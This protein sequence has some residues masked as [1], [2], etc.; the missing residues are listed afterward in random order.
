MGHT[1]EYV[2][3]IL[4]RESFNPPTAIDV[5]GFMECSLE[6]LKDGSCLAILR[7]GSLSPFVI[8]DDDHP[9]PI[10]MQ[11]RSRDGCKTWEK[12]T[13]FYDYG[14][15]PVTRMLADGTVLMAAGRP[16]V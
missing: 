11:T 8:G 13:Y 16:G 14:V 4:Y 7:S 10:M 12:P 1:W 6:F 5:E 9:A 3:H 15:M 2:S